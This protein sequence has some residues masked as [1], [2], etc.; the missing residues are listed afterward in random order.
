MPSQ[1]NGLTK[2]DL[3]IFKVEIIYQFHVVMERI[4]EQVKLVAEGVATV[5]E[6]LD[7]VCKELKEEID[8]KTQLIA[9]ALLELSD[10]VAHS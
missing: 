3:K 6:R 1:K 7:A 10:K 4:I 9:Q 5:N 8:I 2:G